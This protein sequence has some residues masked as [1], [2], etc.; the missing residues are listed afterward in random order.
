MERPLSTEST[1]IA[2]PNASG[3]NH[4][5]HASVKDGRK[6][7]GA[8]TISLFITNL[9]LL[10]LD[11][12]P[13]WPNIAVSSLG[14]QDARTRIKCTEYALYQLFRLHDPATTVEK[15]QPFFPPLE[16][17][18]S[19]NLRA[20]LYRCL[21]ES[22]K[23]SLLPKD[24]VLRKSMLDD[25]QGDKFWEFC[26]GFSSLV[27]RKV[28]LDRKAHYGRSVAEKLST[29]QVVSASQRESMLP[30]AIAHKATLS[31][32]LDEKR[33]KR[34]TYGRLFDLLSDEE[35][36][37]KQRKNKSQEQVRKMQ[38]LRSD[39]LT[40]VD[41]AIEKSWI[42]STELKS[43]LIDGDTCA[44]G[45]GLLV[46][47][48]EKLW[49][50][51]SES[52]LTVSNGAE[53]GL[54]QSLTSRATQQ[55]IRLR[56]WQSYHDRIVAS[57]PVSSR[58]VQPD[59]TSQKPMLHFGKHRELSLKNPVPSNDD[60]P[61]LQPARHISASRYDEILTAMREE[62]RKNSVNRNESD[63]RKL[64]VQPLKRARTQP[65]PPRHRSLD[66]DASPGPRDGHN[67]SPSQTAVPF[68]PRIGRRGLSQMK[69]Y[70]KPKV[71]GQREPIPLK[72]ELFSPL[73]ENRRSNTSL[74]SSSSVLPS[75]TEE[76]E[77]LSGLS[78]ADG[79]DL[80]ME[81]AESSLSGGGRESSRSDSSSKKPASKEERTTLTDATNAEFKVPA[82]P[83]KRQR[84]VNSAMR[85]SLA[86]RT[87]MSIA[88]NSYEDVSRLLPDS[89]AVNSTNA[90]TNDPEGSP[91]SQPSFDRRASLTE[92]TRESI[93]KAPPQQSPKSK[94]A[95]HNR[96]RSSIYPVNQFETPRKARSSTIGIQETAK[97]DAT[98][99]EQLLSPDA[100]YDSVFKSR[101]RIA[102]S[103]VLSPYQEAEPNGNTSL[104]LDVGVSSPL[105]DVGPRI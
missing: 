73:K 13:D 18:Q 54:L 64:S 22:K 67:R 11:L 21:N 98:P 68:G 63:M 36:E 37:L 41:K 81:R 10:N 105:V 53:V 88:F 76:K 102:L 100:E 35:K 15:L 86:E 58:A 65:V 83:E 48:F 71:D 8:S 30:L 69:S 29:A 14:N 34:E 78:V 45:D 79:N 59:S 27:V 16:P 32:I 101:P 5:R 72:S 6:S 1:T 43:A 61:Q 104:D 94:K 28:S 25:C 74:A 90:Q 19:V 33:G 12:L 57:K 49:P 99:I 75:P 40:T 56:M 92:R 4:K 23:N 82:L 62:L 46:E 96:T 44:K 7:D 26:L 50:Q 2:P 3:S 17:L 51:D 77:S 70:E 66:M 24:A 93:S 89:R 47:S 84:E 95:S 55:G 39:K 60:Q 42:G 91:V 20:A 87:R 31:K 97:R 80:M 9:R 38:A 85:P 103:P 52:Y